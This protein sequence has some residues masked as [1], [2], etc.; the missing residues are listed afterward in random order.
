MK[1]ILRAIS[2]AAFLAG[3]TAWA[4]SGGMGNMAKFFGSNKAFTAV[5]DATVA[6]PSQPGPMSMQMN[7]AMLDGKVRMETDMSKTKGAEARA[8]QMKQMGMDK[9]INII[10]PDKKVSYMIFPGLKAYA[11][12]V[13]TDKE[14]A[15]IMNESKMEKT[16]MG[17]EKVDSHDCEK[18]KM[19]VTDKDGQKHDVL[20]WNAKDLRDFPVQMQMSEEGNTITM[21][22]H[23]IKF[24][25]PEESTFEAPAA[26]TKYS[27]FQSMMQT[28][29]MKRAGGGLGAPPK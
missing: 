14:A 8:A 29:M 12:I 24:D 4:Q 10:R 16:P 25:K 15:D 9:T 17:K 27:S 3:T 23:D 28:E 1:R 2:V 20:V 11:E 18:I 21:K 26:F 22:F 13:M 19:T 7:M 6:A 5:A